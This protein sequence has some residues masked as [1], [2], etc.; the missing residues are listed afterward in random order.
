MNIHPAL[1][2]SFPGLHVQQK[3]IDWGVRFSGCTVHFVAAEVDM[4]PIILQA[5]VPVLQDDTERDAGRPDSRRGTQ[6]LSRS[7]AALFP[8]E[9][10]GP[11]P[12]GF[13]SGIDSKR[14]KR[15]RARAMSGN[16]YDELKARGFVAQ[17]SDEA[18][19]RKMLGKKL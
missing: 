17:V 13:H 10:R 12:P 5:A 14:S 2:P 15:E 9:A 4:G 6:D 19:V 16:I 11:R 1:L 18:A 3:A 8:G 7:G